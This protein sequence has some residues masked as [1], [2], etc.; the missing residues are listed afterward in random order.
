MLPKYLRIQYKKYCFNVHL[1]TK[2]LKFFSQIKSYHQNP[3]KLNLILLKLRQ[4][5]IK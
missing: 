3:K 5:F 1:Q 2:K 4:S